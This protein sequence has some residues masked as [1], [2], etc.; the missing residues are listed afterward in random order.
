LSYNIQQANNVVLVSRLLQTDSLAHAGAIDQYDSIEYSDEIFKANAS[1]GFA[2]LVTGATYQE[3]VK[4]CKSFTP[5]IEVKGESK[6]AFAVKLALLYDSAKAKRFLKRDNEEEII[7][8]RGNAEIPDVKIRTQRERMESSAEF[9]VL[10]YAL[11]WTQLLNGEYLP[12]MFE[13]K[14]VIVGF[15]GDYY[16]DPSWSDKFFTPLNSKVAGRANP[17]MFGA[18]VHANI[19]AMILNEDYVDGLP[20]WMEYIIAII[21]CFLNVLLLY[22][23]DT[24]FPIWFDGLQVIIQIIEIILVSGI[25]V[26]VFAKLNFKLDLTL[27]LGA[28]ALVGPCFDVYKSLEMTI[29]N[30]LK[31]RFGAVSI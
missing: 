4:I 5:Q 3:D 28:L 24:R 31:G 15:L 27:T 18:V 11:D 9:H 25:I 2:N 29:I 19:L 26:F 22:W 14:I 30:K 21:I 6:I 1:H 8:F 10:C 17:D 12:E 23:I 16:G 13:D 7:N 20:E